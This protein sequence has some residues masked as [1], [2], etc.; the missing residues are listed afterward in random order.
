LQLAVADPLKIDQQ[1]SRFSLF[2]THL[3]PYIFQL[4]LVT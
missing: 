3:R 1:L 4:A 2:R